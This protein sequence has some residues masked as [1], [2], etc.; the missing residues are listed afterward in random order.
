MVPVFVCLSDG[1]EHECVMY[2]IFFCVFNGFVSKMEAYK[3]L[4]PNVPDYLCSALELIRFSCQSVSYSSV[5]HKKHI[6]RTVMSDGESLK[7]RKNFH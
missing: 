6:I 1:S 2:I 5:K 4:S 3:T 7:M